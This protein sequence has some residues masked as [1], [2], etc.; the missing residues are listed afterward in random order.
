M[1]SIVMSSGVP[2]MIDFVAVTHTAICWQSQ[3]ASYT[4]DLQVSRER[5][6]QKRN[7]AA[8]HRAACGHVLQ[9]DLL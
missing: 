8:K 2:H 6:E 9:R 5:S 4:H 7:L 1:C 3:S